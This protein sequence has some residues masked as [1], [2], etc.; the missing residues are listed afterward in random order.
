MAQAVSSPP[1]PWWKVG[2]MWLVVGGP[3]VVVVASFV[4]LYL[5]IRTPDP[6]YTDPPRA[7]AAVRQAADPSAQPALTPAMQARNHAATGGVA[8]PPPASVG[9]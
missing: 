4:T 2:H 1:S 3:L 6:V 5:A 9:N 7:A 8:A